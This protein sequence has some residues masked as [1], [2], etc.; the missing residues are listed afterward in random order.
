MGFR[1]VYISGHQKLRLL[2]ILGIFLIPAL[3]SAQ[4]RKISLK[5]EKKQIEA[6][7]AYTN[8]LLSPMSFICVCVRPGPG[9]CSYL[10]IPC[11]E[12]Y[13]IRGMKG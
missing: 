10:F 11:R 7:I 1:R 12:T 13:S 2:V 6:D 8:Q 3:S 9:I 4:D 5:Q